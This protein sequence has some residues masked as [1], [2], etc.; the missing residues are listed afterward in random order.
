MPTQIPMSIQERA[1]L[2]AQDK[3]SV[4]KQKAA[5][6]NDFNYLS[7]FEDQLDQQRH[8]TSKIFKESVEDDSELEKNKPAFFRKEVTMDSKPPSWK[9]S[10][11]EAWKKLQ[12]SLEMDFDPAEKTSD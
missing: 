12:K 2:D 1:R 8:E 9:E 4:L 5:D 3:Q 6:L 10:E 11:Y 7:L